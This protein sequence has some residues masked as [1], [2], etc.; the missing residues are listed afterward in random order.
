MSDST[1]PVIKLYGVYGYPVGHSLSPL[2]QNEAFKIANLNAVYFPFSVEPERLR[3]AVEA[4][5]ALQMGGI[6]V[7]IPHKQAVIPYLDR[8][9]GDALLTGSVN[10]IVNRNGALIG[11]STDGDGFLLS[12]QKEAG[13]EPADKEVIIL[14]AGGASRA[15]SFALARSKVRSLYLVNR[16]PERAALLRRDLLERLGFEVKVYDYSDPELKRLAAAADLVIN[17][18]PVGIF[19]EVDAVPPFPLEYCA[20]GRLVCDIIYRPLETKWL[21]RA[22][23]LGLRTLGGLGMLIY[24]GI[25]S[26]SLWTGITP[27]EEPL[28]AVLNKALAVSTDQDS[29]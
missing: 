8:I 5:R 23:E 25:L 17:T 24:Q 19:P 26:F 22:S 3:E 12:L 7:T 2:F 9:K 10:T 15:I 11:Y 21:K 6:N 4:V 29:D 20:A 1:F 18:T 27:S 28:R 16:N 13:F 14:G